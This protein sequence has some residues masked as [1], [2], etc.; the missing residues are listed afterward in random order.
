[1]KTKLNLV[2][3]GLF[4][5]A[6]GTGFGQPVINQQ[7][8]SCSNV[9]GTTAT[10]TVTATGTEPLAYQWQKL[11]ADWT[12]LADRTNTALALTNV[13]TGDA[14]DYRVVVTNADG[15]VTSDVAHLTVRL[16]PTPPRIT[17]TISLQHQA[18]D[19]GTGTSFGVTA[20][21]TAPLFYQWRLDGHELPGKTRSTL[22]INPA[23][24]ADEGDY[25]VVVTNVV[26]AVTS[27]WAR[28]WVVPRATNFIKNNFTNALGRLPYFYLLPTNY[29]AARTYP[30]WFNFHGTPGDETVMTTPNYGYPGY[31]NLPGVKAFASFRQQAQDP[32]IVLWPTR[33]AGDQSWTDS[34]LRQASALLD[35]FIA[36]FGVDTNRIFITGA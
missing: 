5:A 36:Q 19:V 14:M 25:T 13:Q 26:G 22:T 18:V 7:P 6:V 10:F 34:Y 33:R 4:L 24:P 2:A 21:G 17:P 9:V 11:S 28:L 1:M 8:Q 15:A 27:E 35:Q 23:Q 20:S 3:A 12:D 29:N 31:L 32:V 30:L 16:P